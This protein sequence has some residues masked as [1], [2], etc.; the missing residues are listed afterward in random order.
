MPDSFLR[1]VCSWKPWQ[2]LGRNPPIPEVALECS[3]STESDGDNLLGIAS[4][5]LKALMGRKENGRIRPGEL[6]RR[7]ESIGNTG[8]EKV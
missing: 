2:F 1:R 8:D 5:Y 7:V 6:A 3:V 4:K